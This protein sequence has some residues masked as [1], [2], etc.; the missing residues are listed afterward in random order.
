MK[1]QDDNDY[2]LENYIDRVHEKFS[3]LIHYTPQFHKK[4]KKFKFTGQVNLSDII[5]HH[6][7]N[8]KKQ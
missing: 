2:K 8:L 7:W 4:D 5:I 6:K 1:L 3:N